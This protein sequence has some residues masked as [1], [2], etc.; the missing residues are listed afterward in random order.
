MDLG[1]RP[2]VKTWLSHLPREMPDSGKTHL[3]A[4]FFHAVDKGLRFLKH[5]SQFLFLPAPEMSI[6][7]CLCNILSAYID[8]I[9]SHGGFG[10]AG[11]CP[12]SDIVWCEIASKV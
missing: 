8:F 5:H 12:W 6:I 3:Q 1:W 11:N 9:G 2:F 10:N 7:S 4:L